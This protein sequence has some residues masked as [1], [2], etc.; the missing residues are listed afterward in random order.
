M[1]NLKC[2]LKSIKENNFMNLLALF[3]ISLANYTAL[4]FLL[5]NYGNIDAKKVKSVVITFTFFSSISLVLLVMCI[6]FEWLFDKHTVIG[7][8]IGVFLLLTFIAMFFTLAHLLSSY[9]ESLHAMNLA[10]VSLIF[11]I[12]T[13]AL[14]S[15]FFDGESWASTM[16]SYKLSKAGKLAKFSVQLYLI[17][18][19]TTFTIW[20]YI[21]HTKDGYA[22][23]FFVT[24]AFISI[25]FVSSMLFFYVLYHWSNYNKLLYI[26]FSKLWNYDS[27]YSYQETR[28][29]LN[30]DDLLFRIMIKKSR[31][32]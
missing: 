21:N 17:I 15:I 12:V 25:F 27:E 16:R 8:I 6:F 31:K 32:R 4:H 11:T 1:F 14:T 9:I 2:I 19:S 18:L 10:P 20:H 24:F 22:V 23:A 3:L 29:D 13:F 26:I 5:Y 30:L 7:L 28:P